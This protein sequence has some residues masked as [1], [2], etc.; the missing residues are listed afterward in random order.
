MK[1]VFK[2]SLLASLCLLFVVSCDM[3]D[4]IELDDNLKEGLKSN[5]GD[6]GLV[7]MSD[8]REIQSEVIFHKRYPSNLKLEEAE[9]LWRQ[10]IKELN[11]PSLK[12]AY[13]T[14]WFHFVMTQTGPQTYNGTDGSVY[15]RI[16]YN[17][18]AG[19]YQTGTSLNNPGDD[20]EE[21]N[22][23]FYF[24]RSYIPGEAVQWVEERKAILYLRGTDGWFVTRFYVC[25]LA[26][27]QSIPASGDSYI[28]SSPNVWLDNST[29][30]AWDSYDTGVIGFG[31]LNF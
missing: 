27:D 19:Y 8:A 21:G 16:Y 28:L 30:D 2:L 18:D 6:G 12:S 26:K 14:E 3:N 22:W 7:S 20:R 25:L 31:R 5:T 10:E 9:K 4:K 29:S 11:I 13:S 17:T 15:T 1:T 24:V 23:D